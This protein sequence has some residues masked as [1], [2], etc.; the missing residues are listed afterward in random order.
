MNT[1]F[2]LPKF[3]FVQI[4]EYDAKLYDNEYGEEIVV[5]AHLSYTEYTGVEGN[6]FNDL[7]N[8]KMVQNTDHR[9]S[10]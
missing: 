6:F 5:S 8:L 7:R 9:P 3:F 4:F 2:H 1:L 10:Y